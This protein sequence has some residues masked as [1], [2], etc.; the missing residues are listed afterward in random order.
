MFFIIEDGGLQFWLFYAPPLIY[1]FCP[2]IHDISELY[3]LFCDAGCF[4][5]IFSLVSLLKH[6]KVCLSM[7]F[8]IKSCFNVEWS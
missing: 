1:F 8:L 5:S 3:I 2:K 6:K 7:S 4:P